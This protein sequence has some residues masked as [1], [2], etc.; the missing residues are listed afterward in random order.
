[1]F[2]FVTG[3]PYLVHGSS[4]P[5]VGG[6]SAVDDVSF[7]KTRS[8]TIRL[9][10]VERRLAVGEFLEDSVELGAIAVVQCLQY[11]LL[12]SLD[13]RQRFAEGNVGQV[14]ALV[15]EPPVATAHA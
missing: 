4:A 15:D 14:K 7:G 8:R 11:P 2:I 3:P 5:G 13:G 12:K 9:P 1:M 10:G 6:D